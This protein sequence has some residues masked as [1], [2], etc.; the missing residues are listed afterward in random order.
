MQVKLTLEYDG[1]N[2]SGWQLQRHQDSIQAQVEAALRRIFGVLVRVRAAGRT[3]AGVHALEQVAAAHLP[4]PFDPAELGRALNAL[5]PADIVVHDCVAIGD[6]F[7]PRRDAIRRAYEYRIVNRSCRSAFEC[8]YVW[9][10]S[11]TLE[12]DAMNRAAAIFIGQHDFAAFRTL[13]SGELS[14][15]RRVY[16]SEWT[17][18]PERLIYRVEA[19]SFLR[20]MVRTMVAAM[21]EVGRRRAKPEWIAELLEARDRGRAPASAPAAGLYLTRISYPDVAS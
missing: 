3:D 18:A 20:H 11:E 17:F 14:T 13:G 12:L 16:A 7:D 10:I 1:A 5:L 9:L 8:R 21:V 15:T 19:S 4:R 6:G 2:Y